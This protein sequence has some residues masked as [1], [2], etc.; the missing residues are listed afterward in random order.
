MVSKGN[1]LKIPSWRFLPGLAFVPVC[2]C[3]FLCQNLGSPGLCLPGVCPVCGFVFR[4]LSL[5]AFGVRLPCGRRPEDRHSFSRYPP[6]Y[7][8]QPPSCGIDCQGSAASFLA[9][10]R[11]SC[12]NFGHCIIA[13]MLPF[14]CGFYSRIRSCTS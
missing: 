14:P 9:S 8:S 11:C 4:C 2:V 3:L 5:V 12:R 6:G 7:V 10:V 1:Q 13:L